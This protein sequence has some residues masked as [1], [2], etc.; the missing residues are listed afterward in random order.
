MKRNVFLSLFLLVCI[1]MT[2]PF[3]VFA[4][5]YEGADAL[6]SENIVVINADNGLMVF[7]KNAYEK[8]SVGASAKIMTAILALE[9]FEGI[10]EM[11]ITVPTAATRGVSGGAVLNLKAGEE[12]SVN[13][14]IHATLI[15]GM[16][17]AAQAL[18][19]AIGGSYSNFVSM[20]NEKAM[21][22]GATNTRYDNATGLSSPAYTTAADLAQIALYAYK[23]KRFMEISSKRYH[24]IS[25]TNVH[26]EVTIY[27]K[28][29]L[30]TPQS[31]YYYSKAKGISVGYADES[32]AQIISAVSY[33]NY[34][35]ICIAAGARKTESGT[36]GGYADVKALFSWASYNFAE[37][38]ILDESKILCEMPVRAG[39]NISHVL[40]VP[41][42][43]VY[44][45]LDVDVD[46]SEI[47]LQ[48]MLSY[49]QLTA[50]VSKGDVVGKVIMVLD[51]KPIES[52][53][54]IAK[55]SIRRSAGGGFLLM[56]EKI[57]TNPIVIIVILLFV[58]FLFLYFFQKKKTPRFKTEKNRNHKN[59]NLKN[60]NAKE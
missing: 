15:A 14:L 54:L 4:K 13:D 52:T 7:T 1:V 21:E 39:E 31:E 3:P 41:D 45:F 46:L 56:L 11:K 51:G 28:N 55:T 17:D 9:Y 5:D 35:Y 12:I 36:I 19:L 20:M 58:A 10:P 34:P 60:T 23:N 26:E 48:E 59:K 37:R 16:N 42:R 32:G 38:K 33:G 43:S 27:T 44:T 29:P 6:A 47:T 8:I 50:P 22:L 53:N 49:T 18:A 25:A 24:K 57:F 40:V 2:L 30:L